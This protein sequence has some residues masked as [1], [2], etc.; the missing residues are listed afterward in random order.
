MMLDGNLR[1]QQDVNRPLLAYGDISIR[2]GVYEIYGQSLNVTDGK[3]IFFG[4]PSNPSLDIRAYRE[5]ETVQAGVLINGTI[6]NMQSQ[7]FST[8]NLPESEILSM[9]ITG[10][11]FSDTNNQDQSNLL[12]AAASLGINR[13]GL[14]GLLSSGLGVDTLDFNSESNLEQSSLGLGKYLTPDLFMHY[15]IG[16]FEKESV[17]SLDYILNERLRLEVE[18]GISQSIDMTYRIE[19]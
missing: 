2:E 7:L 3:L 14:T 17:L 19:K 10:K 11:S 4:N 5:T 1:L 16:L 9:L 13:S 12:G 6:R 18:S 8:P 15:E